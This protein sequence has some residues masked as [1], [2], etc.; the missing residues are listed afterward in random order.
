MW[1]WPD[2]EK[3]I[4]RDGRA[5][6]TAGAVRT[7]E[8]CARIMG[9]SKQAVQSAEARALEKLRKD[10]LIRSLAQEAHII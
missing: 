8:E 10:P 3:M 5:A 4:A 7:H 1:S 9:I 6:R 2:V